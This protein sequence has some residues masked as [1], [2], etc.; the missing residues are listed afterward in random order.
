MGTFEVWKLIMGKEG[1]RRDC[2]VGRDFETRKTLVTNETLH[3]CGFAI[4]E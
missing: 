1:R 3:R 4:G 2:E